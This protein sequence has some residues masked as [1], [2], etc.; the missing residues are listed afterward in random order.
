MSG[1]AG[2]AGRALASCRAAFTAAFLP[3]RAAGV[4]WGL[5]KA[6]G[7]SHLP[8]GVQAAGGALPHAI[9]ASGAG[10]SP[11]PGA[12]LTG[13]FESPVAPLLPPIVFGH[14]VPSVPVDN[15]PEL[16]IDGW[17]RSAREGMVE[18]G[19][20]EAPGQ[21]G[22]ATGCAR[23]PAPGPRLSLA[24]SPPRLNS[25]FLGPARPMECVKRTFQPSNLKRKNKHGFRNRC[26]RPPPSPVCARARGLRAQL[27]CPACA[28]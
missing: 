17:L 5:S 18:E 16:D 25:P 27:C 9:P 13:G 26:A 6:A 14:V 3:S 8:K 24:L 19:S 7:P 21:E 15:A 1:A 11:A 4:P 2:R 10:I 23:A 28:G 12:W 20:I 22:D